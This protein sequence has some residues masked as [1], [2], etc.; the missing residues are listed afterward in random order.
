MAQG[1][2]PEIIES[3]PNAVCGSK[4][5]AINLHSVFVLDSSLGPSC[6]RNFREA[7]WSEGWTEAGGC[8]GE[9][10]SWLWNAVK[11]GHA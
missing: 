1:V 8:T 3:R 6:S 7:I 4:Y 2:R 5:N 9:T 10:A 11:P